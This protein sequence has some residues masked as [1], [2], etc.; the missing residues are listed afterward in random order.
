MKYI[1]LFIIT[2]IIGSAYNN[3]HGQV[4]ED[5]DEYIGGLKSEPASLLDYSD[6]SDE[7]I[8][9]VRVNMIFL[10]KND[11]TGGFQENNPDHQ[12]YISDKINNS[13]DY[14]ANIPSNYDPVCY[15]GS[16]GLI[17]DSKIRFSYNVIYINDSYAWDNGGGS[18]SS[19][20]SNLVALNNSI[21][22]NSTHP[23][24]NMFYT[25]DSVSYENI[26]TSQ[27]CPVEHGMPTTSCTYW[28]SFSNLNKNQTVHMRCN[29]TKYYWMVNCVVGN[30][31]WGSPDQETVYGWM[32]PGRLEAHEL[33]HNFNLD[34][35]HKTNCDCDQHLM[36]HNSCGYGNFLSPLE[37]EKMHKALSQSSARRYVTETTYSQTPIQVNQSNSWS[38][39]IRIY[40]GLNI[41]NGVTFQINDELIIPSETDIVVTGYSTFL[42]SGAT[43]YT[44]HTNSVLD[45]I[46]Q[47]NS[48]VT[49][50]NS[51][52]ENCNISVQSGS[53]IITNSTIELGNNSNFSIAQGATFTMNSG[54]I[55]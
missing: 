5:I 25:E 40:R 1:I 54:C 29:F 52:I 20:P 8:K 3:L 17:S 6:I 53:L 21:I 4:F 28:P 7:P 15:D 37:I 31:Y 11:G 14:M 19:L 13:N 2:T 33:A 46:V 51:S 42:T 50:S 55:Y 22:Q 12:Q 36:M 32:K 10:H 45:L 47:Q 30:S 9:Y 26:V 39:S 16:E 41:C 18:C 35:I 44:P 43:I 48:D 23:A 49:L 34:D 38:S 27:N 24:I